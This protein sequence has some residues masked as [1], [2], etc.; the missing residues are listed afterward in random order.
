MKAALG[1][2]RLDGETVH[3]GTC[4]GKRARP[5]STCVQRRSRC[6]AAAD[7]QEETF[8]RSFMCCVF[9]HGEAI[10]INDVPG[11]A[12][13]QH[14]VKP[15]VV[16]GRFDAGSSRQRPDPRREIGGALGGGQRRRPRSAQR[17]AWKLTCA[18][19]TPSTI[20]RTASPGNQIRRVTEGSAFQRILQDVAPAYCR[21][22]SDDGVPFE[23][24]S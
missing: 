5:A 4:R 19:A 2:A 22:P 12:Y 10:A 13:D 14:C 8:A 21:A 9:A 18:R 1:R 23:P 24:T 15:V 7:R 20:R 16:R 11:L 6:R 3:L 17:D